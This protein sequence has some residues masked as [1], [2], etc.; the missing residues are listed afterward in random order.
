M[1]YQSRSRPEPLERE[2][3]PYALVYRWGW[4]Y[5]A[6]HCH[7]RR[8][9]RTF[10]VDR[11]R[12][13]MLLEEPFDVPAEFDVQEYLAAEPY[14]QPHLNVCL[15]FGPEAALAARDDQAVWD[16]MDERPDGSVVVSFGAPSIE[17]AAQQAFY[18]GPQ[19]TVL[20]PA[21]LR[22]LV[23]EQAQAIAAL[24]AADPSSAAIDAWAGIDSGSRGEDSA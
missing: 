18:Y 6:G 3:D 2:L 16:R 20:E 22:T 9:V 14:T 10:R 23:Q 11:I 21:K 13:L 19:V 8:V 12:Q 15:R 1:V 4:W 7:L 24:Y 5:V 17:W